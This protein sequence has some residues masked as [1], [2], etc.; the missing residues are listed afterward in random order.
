MPYLINGQPVP[1]QFIREE[2]TRLSRDLR[3]Q[4]I[5]DETE[6]ARQLQLAAEQSAIDKLLVEQAAAA[7]PRPVDPTLIEREAT[8]VKTNGNCRSAFD[9]TAVRA[10]AE[11]HLR[12]Q[13]ILEEIL[14]T[15]AAPTPDQIQACYEQFREHFQ[16]PEIFHAAHIV[17]HVNGERNEE[18]ARAEIEAALAELDRGDL[19]GEVADRHSDCKGNGGDLGRFPAGQM[20]DEFEE[21]LRALE[22]GKRTG[23]FRTPFGFHIAELRGRTPAGPATFDQ[24]RE[25]IERTLTLMN[26]HEVFTRAAAKLRAHADIRYVPA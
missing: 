13:R 7:D 1:D 18:R 23:I 19:F 24:V 6:R 12:I 10:G 14:A 11:K 25:L 22:P 2:S 20:V 15:A 8:S 9:D 3:W 17:V 26:R 4:D 5:A 21:A 16:M